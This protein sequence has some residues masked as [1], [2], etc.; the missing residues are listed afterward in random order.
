MD[1][2]RARELLS[3]GRAAVLR[4]NRWRSREDPPPSLRRAQLARA[5]LTDAN[6]ANVDLE[7]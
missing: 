1:R 5:D 7:H 3:G 2:E 6:L 4:W